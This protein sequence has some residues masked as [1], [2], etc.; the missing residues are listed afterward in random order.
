M[1]KGELAAKLAP[2]VPKVTVH[3]L[4]VT[5]AKIQSPVD[6]TP[7]LRLSNLLW[8]VSVASL[9]IKV[10]TCCGVL[11]LGELS[12]VTYESSPVRLSALNY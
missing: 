9:S 2:Q 7:K 1:E 11:A 5:L 10:T 8:C 3:K 4:R 12:N 6:A